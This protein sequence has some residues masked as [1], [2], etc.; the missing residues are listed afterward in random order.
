ML[1]DLLECLS[2]EITPF[3][4]EVELIVSD[5]CSTDHTPEVAEQ[6][7]KKVGIRY[8]RNS[9]NIGFASNVKIMVEQLAT[10]EFCLIVG[11]DDIVRRGIIEKILKTIREYPEIDYIFMNLNFVHIQRRVD[12]LKRITEPVDIS[13][14]HD[15]MCYRQ[16]DSYVK[17]GEDVISFTHMAGLFGPMPSNIFRRSQWKEVKLD[18]GRVSDFPLFESALP[19]IAGIAHMIVAK[20]CFYI[21]Y[22]Y[23]AFS[24]MTQEWFDHWWP[25]VLLGPIL[26]VSD[27][28]EELGARKEMVD[29]YRKLVFKHQPAA[30]YFWMLLMKK[31]NVYHGHFSLVSLVKRYYMYPEFWE[32]IFRPIA[33]KI[34]FYYRNPVKLPQS[35]MRKLRAW[36]G[37][38]GGRMASGSRD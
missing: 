35:I 15:V 21:G 3:N 1:R 8:H 5:N 24:S 30:Y 25:T 2:I 4:N 9:K 7:S 11:D 38:R 13:K 16:E 19:H 32:M 36:H 12:L 28:F 18:P 33:A 26:T 17:C 20:P 10:G 14:I 29:K 22:P 31:D 6:M 34:K 23:V 27:L 37:S